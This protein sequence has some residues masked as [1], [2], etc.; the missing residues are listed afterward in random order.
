M[1]NTNL[2]ICVT[3]L[4]FAV[5]IIFIAGRAFVFNEYDHVYRL[6]CLEFV[7]LSFIIL[8]LTLSFFFLYDIIAQIFVLFIISVAAAESVV[9]LTIL[10]LYYRSW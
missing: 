8:Y 5:F 3:A 1:N 2:F 7:I 4:F 10:L 6:I 9:G